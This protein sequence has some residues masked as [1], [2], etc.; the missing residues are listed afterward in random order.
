YFKIKEVGRYLPEMTPSLV[1]GELQGIIVVPS[2][3][4][5]YAIKGSESVPLMV[6][7]DGSDPNTA[8]FVE[9]YVLGAWQHGQIM[10]Q[11]DSGILYPPPIEVLSRFWFNEELTSR[12]FLVPSSIAI[13]L[14]IIGTLL[15]A[16][17]VAREWE[18]GTM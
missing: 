13:I 16:L 10:V 1:S 2:Y 11:Q 14:T 15:T 17:V 5:E 4:A 9:N 18:R 8:N 7:T 12:N 3:F 6:L